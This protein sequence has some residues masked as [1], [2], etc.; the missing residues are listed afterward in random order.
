MQSAVVS[1]LG[2]RKR[3]IIDVPS[4]PT[5]ANIYD[6]LPPPSPV[7]SPPSPVDSLFGKSD[8]GK[9]IMDVVIIVIIW[10]MN[11]LW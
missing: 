8:D 11:Y 1:I 3:E 6:E 10:L 9:V 4:S 5:I 7:D 2:K